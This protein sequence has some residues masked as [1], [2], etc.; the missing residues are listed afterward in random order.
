[1]EYPKGRQNNY[2]DEG[3]YY[4]NLSKAT[5]GFIKRRDAV[6]HTQK[7]KSLTTTRAEIER[8]GVT[9]IDEGLFSRAAQ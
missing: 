1:M 7:K 2:F 9:K 8:K 4:R 3:F 6:T 5:T